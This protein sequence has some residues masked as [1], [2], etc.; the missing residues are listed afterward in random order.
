MVRVLVNALVARGKKDEVER[1]LRSELDTA[2]PNERNASMLGILYAADGNWDKA[3][4]PLSLAVKLA[5][6]EGYCRL[7]Q[8]VAL[9]R[10]GNDDEYRRQCHE[11]LQVVPD[12]WSATA[13]LLL[14]V[15]GADFD[16][17]C[18]LV[19]EAGKA[20]DALINGQLE[21]ASPSSSCGEGNSMRRADRAMRLLS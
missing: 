20:N 3:I 13:A 18:A 7:F 8:A 16:R 6:N 10:T 9:L 12:L 15:G 1:L 14:P 17:A 2:H 19:D 21:S 11:A 4:A 5:P